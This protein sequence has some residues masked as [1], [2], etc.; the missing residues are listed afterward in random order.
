M[1]VGD[2][3]EV[4]SVMEG[5]HPVGIITAVVEERSD[6]PRFMLCFYLD[7]DHEVLSYDEEFEVISKSR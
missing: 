3:I 6:Q 2:L 7:G 4:C 1:K 5:V